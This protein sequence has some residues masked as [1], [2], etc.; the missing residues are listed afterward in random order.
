MPPTIHCK[1]NDAEQVAQCR[2]R[3]DVKSERNIMGQLSR[4]M[5]CVMIL[6]KV[7]SGMKA[8]GRHARCKVVECT[9]AAPT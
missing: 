2:T 4:L 9:F 1:E 8:F 5:M 6:S 3:I 7:F